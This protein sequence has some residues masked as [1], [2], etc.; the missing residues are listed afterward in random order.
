MK[1]LN[2]QFNTEIWKEGNMYVSYVPQLDLAS[3][4]KTV[5]GAKKNI[6]KTI[7]LFFEE[8]EKMGTTKDVLEEAGFSFDKTWEAPE[9][10]AIEKMRFAF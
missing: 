1:N 5:G 7:K 9:I 8:T 3:C 4:G 10:I 2:I 6:Q